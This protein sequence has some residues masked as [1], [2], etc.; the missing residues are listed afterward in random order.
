MV[1][2]WARSRH[3]YDIYATAECLE[4]TAATLAAIYRVR[5]LEQRGLVSRGEGGGEGGETAEGKRIEV[6]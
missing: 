4:Y 1:S 6:T 2:L 5:S 3:F